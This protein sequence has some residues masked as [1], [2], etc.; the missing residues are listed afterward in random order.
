MHPYLPIVLSIVVAVVFSL[1]F[2][3]LSYFFG[4]KRPLATKNSVFECG[5]PPIG[6]TR[7]R[8]SVKFYLVAVLF[9]LFDL[10]AVFLFPWSTVYR[11]FVEQGAASFVL[12]EMALFIGVLFMGWFYCLRRGAFEWD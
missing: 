11:S 10:E 5:M 7:Q 2:V 12:M 8:F 9:L 1:S 3:G 4:P 6:G